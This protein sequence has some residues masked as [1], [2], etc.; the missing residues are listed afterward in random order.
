MS[1]TSGKLVYC[2]LCLNSHD[3]GDEVH[4]IFSSMEKARAWA[5]AD[6]RPH[7]IYDYVID[8]PER[9]EMRNT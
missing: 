8:V 7:I 1:S 4:H 3:P 9:R 2:V 5:E 6:I